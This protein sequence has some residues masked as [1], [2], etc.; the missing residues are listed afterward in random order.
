[1][2]GKTRLVPC[3]FVWSNGDLIVP[4]EKNINLA[5]VMAIALVIASKKLQRHTGIAA[6]DWRKELM[7]QALEKFNRMS[8]RQIEK[9]IAENFG[10]L[11]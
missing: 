11:E 1:M 2:D 8:V 5:L 3:A 10:M 6:A 9:F 4:N 7:E